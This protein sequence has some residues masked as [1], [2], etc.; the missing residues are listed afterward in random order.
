MGLMLAPIILVLIAGVLLISMFGSALNLVST[1]GEITY[2]ENIFGDYADAQYATEFGGTAD[3]EDHLLLV[4]LVEDEECYDYAFMAWVGDDV[5][6]QINELFGSNASHLGRAIQNSAIN[7]ESYKYS[8]DSGIAS[9][10]RTMQGHVAALGLEDSF[11]CSTKTTEDYTS[12]LINKTSL[13]LTEATVNR[14]L[15]EFTEATGIAVAVVVEDIDE[16]FPRVASD[17]DVFSLVFAILLIV[18]AVILAVRGYRNY[19]KNRKDGGNGNGDAGNGDAGSGAPKNDGKNH[20][21]GTGWSYN[22]N[23]R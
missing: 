11:V 10:M 2:D 5:D 13:T 21:S 9:V 3:Y 22:R 6:P 4:F 17:F 1:G 20:R 7:S 16:V 12:R 15:T 18:I 14:A 19:K 23:E 8:L